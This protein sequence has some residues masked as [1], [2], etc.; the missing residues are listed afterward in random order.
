MLGRLRPRERLLEEELAK[1]FDANRNVVRAALA[2]LETMGIIVR[3]PN[4]GAAVRD[5]SPVEVEQIYDVRQLLEGH[6][7]AIM[8]LPAAPEVLEKLRA[9]QTRHSKAVDEHEPRTV[10]RANLEFP[11]RAL[12]WLRQS[13]SC[14]TDQR[15]RL[16]R[17][18]KSPFMPLP[19][20]SWSTVPARSTD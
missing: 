16:T 19:T 13:L 11:P 20:R 17:P 10:F 6:A 4:Q 5:F 15:A 9:I 8:P 7:A 3:Q 18:R 14:Q 12:R 1:H 2:E